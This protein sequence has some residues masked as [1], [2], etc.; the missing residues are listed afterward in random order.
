MSFFFGILRKQPQKRGPDRLQMAKLRETTSLSKK[1]PVCGP[2]FF[3]CFPAPIRLVGGGASLPP[4]LPRLVQ[5]LKL[6]NLL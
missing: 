3:I 2:V 4:P 1:V 6:W 5:T